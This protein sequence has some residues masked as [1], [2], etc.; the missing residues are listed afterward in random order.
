[1][2]LNCQ[3]F[4]PLN[5]GITDT[6]AHT[7]CSFYLNVSPAVKASSFGEASMLHTGNQINQALGDCLSAGLM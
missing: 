7:P 2:A 5:S 4:Q 1:M 3:H 6:F